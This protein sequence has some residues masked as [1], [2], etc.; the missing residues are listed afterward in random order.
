MKKSKIARWIA[1][2]FTA[3]TFLFALIIPMGGT[4][5]GLLDR[6]GSVAS[7]DKVTASASGITRPSGSTF[8]QLVDGSSYIYTDKTL[9]QAT[10]A[11]NSTEDF[12][13][14]AVNTSLT[15]GTADN[16]YVI[17]NRI[18]WENFVQW[19]AKDA[20]FGAGRVFVLASD[21][22]FAETTSSDGTALPPFHMV[23]V[24]QGAFYGTGHSLKNITNT[25]WVYYNKATSSY[26]AVTNAANYTN[27]GFG[28]FGKIQDA[29]VTDLIVENFSFTNV[30]QVTSISV[31][32][33]SA[34]GGVAGVTY[35]NSYVLNC[36]TSG[37]IA[38]VSFVAGRGSQFGWPS[39]IVGSHRNTNTTNRNLYIYRC[40]AEVS[41]DA[42]TA[43]NFHQTGAG[44]IGEVWETAYCYVYDC[45]AN[46]SVNTPARSI[47]SHIGACTGWSNGYIYI[48][49]FVGSTT[50]TPDVTEPRSGALGGATFGTLKKMSGWTASRAR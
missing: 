9:M 40:S 28:V 39:G 38:H 25:D 10:H 3:F 37:H 7:S 1:A 48:E 50:N 35:G 32:D 49:N 44:I 36:Q 20:T 30:Q 2:G 14:K 15:H 31:W 23:G 18:D 21:I 45:A 24:F 34:I 42:P 6:G 46:V 47:Y 33:G 22:D 41:I 12:T 5:F 19:T 29:E 27:G 16:P 26:A 17:E 8:G 13:S 43:S 4:L 11:G